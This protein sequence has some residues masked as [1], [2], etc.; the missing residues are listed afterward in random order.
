M[1]RQRSRA[2]ARS[3]LLSLAIAPLWAACGAEADPASVDSSAAPVLAAALDREYE[4]PTF[5]LRIRTPGSWS[6]ASDA[7][8]EKL[9]HRSVA[10]LRGA[11]EADRAARAAKL[12]STQ[13]LLTVSRHPLGADV[14]SNPH[15]QVIAERLAPSGDVRSAH[16]FLFVMTRSLEQSALPYRRLGAPRTEVL[17]GSDFARQDTALEVSG[18]T[19]LQTHLARITRGHVLCIS[20]AYT[21]ADEREELLRIAHTLELE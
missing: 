12:A 9:R 15:I 7:M 14:P 18:R 4:S 3:A 8:L 21:R 16:D 10:L 6:T 13:Q 1:T 5:G 17:G 19:M 11:T 2:C 20:L